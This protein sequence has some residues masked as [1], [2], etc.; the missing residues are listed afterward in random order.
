MFNLSHTTYELQLNPSILLVV[1]EFG[2]DFR[3]VLTEFEK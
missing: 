1:Q 2:A 3:A